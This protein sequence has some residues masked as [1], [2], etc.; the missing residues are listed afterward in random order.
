M[1]VRTLL[2]GVLP[3]VGDTTAVSFLG[4]SRNSALFQHGRMFYGLNR[5]DVPPNEHEQASYLNQLNRD[6]G[7]PRKWCPSLKVA[8]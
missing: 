7:Q 1:Y 5:S 8:E 3:A 6:D 2:R 4:S